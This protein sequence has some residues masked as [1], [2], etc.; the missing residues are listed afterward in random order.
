[1]ILVRDILS[2]L[3]IDL[4]LSENIIRVNGGMFEGRTDPVKDILNINFNL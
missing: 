4:F 3:R 1:M 2:E